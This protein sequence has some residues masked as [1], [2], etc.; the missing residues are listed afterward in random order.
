M[1]CTKYAYYVYNMFFFYN[2]FKEIFMHKKQKKTI[3][4]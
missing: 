4:C 1:D 3:E 2:I